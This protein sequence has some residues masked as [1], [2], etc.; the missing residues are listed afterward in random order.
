MTQAFSARNIPGVWSDSMTGRILL[1]GILLTNYT[2][3]FAQSATARL[4]RGIDRFE[5]RKCPEAIQD[6]R[7]VQPQLPK[8]ADYVAFYLASCWVELKDYTQ[9][10]R[11]LAAFRN[12]STP[13]PLAGKAALLEAKALAETG[14]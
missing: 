2:P 13:S 8:L 9:T 10:G 1:F 14:S 5:N 12:L 6:L 3:L 7:A 4:A 11:E